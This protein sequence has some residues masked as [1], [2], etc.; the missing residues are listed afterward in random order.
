MEPIEQ[1][2]SIVFISNTENIEPGMISSVPAETTA[3]DLNDSASAK[4]GFPGNPHPSVCGT[5]T[6]GN[7]IR[8]V[9]LIAPT[10]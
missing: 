4:A 9:Y 3:A 7:S 5:W 10:S 8:T 2:T 1:P 6:I